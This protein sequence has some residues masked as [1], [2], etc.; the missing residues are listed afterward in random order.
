MQANKSNHK[1]YYPSTLPLLA[2]A[3]NEVCNAAE[4]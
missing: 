2:V 4:L 3:R 1:Y